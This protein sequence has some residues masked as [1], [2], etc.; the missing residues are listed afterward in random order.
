MR[1]HTKDRFWKFVNKSGPLASRPASRIHPEIQNTRC[2]VWTGAFR[3]THNYGQFG[4]RGKTYKAHRFAYKLETGEW[5]SSKIPLLHKC[6]NT[7][8]IRPL[9]TFE[10]THE[11]NMADM[12][13]KNRQ[14]VGD[15]HGSRLHPERLIRGKK[16]H[17]AHPPATRTIGERNR[18]AKLTYEDV[19]AIRKLWSTGNYF[20]RELA[21]KY[22]VLQTT[23][24]RVVT[25]QT[26]R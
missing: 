5:L 21:E 6:D 10:G 20:Q 24:G 23:I 22:N 19:A 4:Y 3:G 8:C 2:W 16:W 15:K 17:R 9:H 11:I 1:Q 12:K 18:H 26:W 7:T 25:N 14:A 13:A